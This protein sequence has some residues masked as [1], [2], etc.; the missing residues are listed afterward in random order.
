M[1]ADRGVGFGNHHNALNVYEIDQTDGLVRADRRGLKTANRAS[2]VIL[3]VG[4]GMVQ[5]RSGDESSKKEQGKTN[6]YA[7]VQGHVNTR[8]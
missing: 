8:Y 7:F 6:E 3:T 5:I 1:M 4:F 2:G